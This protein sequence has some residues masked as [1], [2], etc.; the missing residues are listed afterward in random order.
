M[1]TTSASVRFTVWSNAMLTGACDPDTAA[2]QIL[3]DDVGHHVAGLTAHPEPATLPVALNLL[4]ATGTTQAHLALPIPGDPIGLAGP[5]TFNE[6]ALESGEAVV[7]TGAGIGLVPAY[8]GPAVQ[9]TALTATSPMPA[10]F[11]EADRGLRMALIDA[12]ESLAALDVA[13]WKPEIADALIDIRKIGSGRNDDLAPGYQPRAVKAA[14]TARRCLAIAD[15]ALEDDGAAV[16]GAEADAR[17]R[18]LLDLAAAARRA[19]VAA[20]APPVPG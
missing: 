6:A 1:L 10:D 11:G 7:L 5:P 19:L 13:R 3:G 17:R 9:W 8:V 18:T 16:T 2:H 15:A 12:A 4:R 20:C 14:A